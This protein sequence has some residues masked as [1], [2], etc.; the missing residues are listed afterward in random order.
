MPCLLH[1]LLDDFLHY[2]NLLYLGSTCSAGTRGAMRAS[3][4]LVLPA[5][6]RASPRL[7]ARNPVGP[8]SAT[9]AFQNSSSLPVKSGARRGQPCRLL[10]ALG[11]RTQQYPPEAETRKLCRNIPLGRCPSW[12]PQFQAALAEASRRFSAPV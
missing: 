6:E 1:I 10:Q 5:K 4:P 2:N 12:N 9:P 7:S 11:V 3:L 8:C